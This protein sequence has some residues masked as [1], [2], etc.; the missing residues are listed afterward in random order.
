MYTNLK[1][2]SVIIHLL[3]SIEDKL[4]PFLASWMLPQ[5]QQ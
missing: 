2:E 4:F 3:E 5:R 1:G